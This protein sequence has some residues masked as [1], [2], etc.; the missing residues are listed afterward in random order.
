MLKLTKFDMCLGIL[1]LTT[2][3]SMNKSKK[4]I[5]NSCMQ[6]I[7]IE[8]ITKI[9]LLYQCRPVRSTLGLSRLAAGRLER[10]E[11][12]LNQNKILK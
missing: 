4:K 8:H 10:N 11:N 12:I 7:S 1:P 3:D 2:N 6:I 5:T 9:D